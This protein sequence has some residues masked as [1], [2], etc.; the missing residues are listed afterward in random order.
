MRGL[1][2]MPFCGVVL[3]VIALICAWVGLQVAI[4]MLV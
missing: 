3:G 4:Y 2:E 1:I